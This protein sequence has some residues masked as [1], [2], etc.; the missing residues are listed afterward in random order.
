[1]AI[2]DQV[3]ELLHHPFFPVAWLTETARIG[4]VERHTSLVA[5]EPSGQTVTID[6]V[7]MLDSTTLMSCLAR[8]GRHSD[9]NRGRLASLYPR[10]TAAFRRDYQEFLDSCPTMA[11][12]GPRLIILA[13]DVDTELRGALDSLLGTGVQLFRISLHE[14]RQGILVSL[15]EV[16]PHEASFRSIA[17]AARH[18]EIGAPSAIT[19]E[20]V[21]DWDDEQVEEAEDATAEG[22][23]SDDTV[24]ADTGEADAGEDA[25]GPVDGAESEVEEPVVTEPDVIEPAEAVEFVNEVDHEP[26]LGEGPAYAAE[27]PAESDHVDRVD[28]GVTDDRDDRGDTSVQHV[29]SETTGEPADQEGDADAPLPPELSKPAY[30]STAGNIGWGP[31]NAERLESLSAG[32]LSGTM[33]D[34]DT[35]VWLIVDQYGELDVT[36]KSLRRRVNAKGRLVREGLIVDGVTYPGP[37]EAAEA[38]TGRPADGWR[39]W[40]LSDGRRLSDLR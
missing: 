11:K 24:D 18:E 2:R 16:R 17:Q 6:V 30:L 31:K 38:L 13:L 20:E 19:A 12:P 10:G 34:R 28:H 26:S 21:G 1:M 32:V 27:E 3:T 7:P 25:D 9:M 15:D 37:D 29:E 4:Q 5:L 36:F 22:E 40:R 35:P 33:S 8:A 14:T 39:V 23:V